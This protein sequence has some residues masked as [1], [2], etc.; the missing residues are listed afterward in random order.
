MGDLD[1]QLRSFGWV[2]LKLDANLFTQVCV[3]VCVVCTDLS[4][5]NS[6]V[7]LEGKTTA[8]NSL[9]APSVSVPAPQNG[10]GLGNHN[11]P[12]TQKINEKS[13]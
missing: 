12:P 4:L 13:V 5:A 1:R 2:E 8:P 11:R 9:V 10:G 7:V 3:C 6:A